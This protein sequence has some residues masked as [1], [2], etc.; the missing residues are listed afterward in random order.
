[1]PIMEMRNTVSL[2]KIP[3]EMARSRGYRK[4]MVKPAVVK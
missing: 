4:G 3:V 2:D 1:M